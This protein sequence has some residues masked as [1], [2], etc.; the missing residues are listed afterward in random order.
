MTNRLA[1]VVDDS[2][3]A[4][5]TLKRMLEKHGVETDTA[6]KI[7]K[8]IKDGKAYV[9]SLG[10]EEISEYDSQPEGIRKLILES[11]ALTKKNLTCLYGSNSPKHVSTTVRLL[12]STATVIA[13]P[14]LSISNLVAF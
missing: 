1:L 13:R 12:I 3:T 4:R 14:R 9:D 2:K 7:V 11:L 5:V 8:L 6:R 10:P